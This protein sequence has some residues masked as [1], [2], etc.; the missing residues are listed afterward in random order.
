MKLESTVAMLNPR[1]EDPHTVLIQG[2][3]VAQVE[4]THL[5]HHPPAAPPGDD[6]L[7]LMWR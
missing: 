3:P 4:N 6:D 7:F 1:E 5:H 2:Q